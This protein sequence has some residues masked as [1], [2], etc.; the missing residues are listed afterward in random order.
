MANPVRY[1]QEDKDKYK[2]ATAFVKDIFNKKLGINIGNPGDLVEG[3]AFRDFSSDYAR[4]LIIDLVE[5]DL[6]EGLK[7]IHLG[8]FTAVKVINSQKRKVDVEKFRDLTSNVYLT[9]LDLYP[10]AVISPS[11]HR[12]L[13]HGWETIQ[14]NDSLRL[15]NISEEGLEAL[16]KWIRRLR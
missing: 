5:D 9:I 1:T 13:G 16:N 8:L 15:G 6:K 14:L 11:V 10:W 3:N 4:G 12:I 7:E 2:S